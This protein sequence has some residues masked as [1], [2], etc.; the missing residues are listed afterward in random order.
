MFKTNPQKKITKELILKHERQETLLEHY[1]GIPVERGLFISPLREDTNPT[2]SFYVNSSG[3]IIFKDFNGSFS[4]N[5]ISVVMYKYKLTYPQALTKIAKDFNIIEGIDN[6]I[7]TK[8]LNLPTT[9]TAASIKVKRREFTT[10]DLGWWKQYGIDKDMLNHYKVFALDY[11]WLNDDLY[12][13]YSNS[14]AY[15]YYFQRNRWKIYFPRKSKFRFICNTNVLQGSQQLTEGDY[16][17]ITKSLKDVM[18]FRSFGI[19]AVAPQAES[20]I[21]T[22][23]Q[24]QA[25]SSR[26]KHIIVNYDYDRAGCR[27]MIR[28]RKQFGLKCMFFGDSLCNEKKKAK[29]ISDYRKL[30]GH[31]KTKELLEKCKQCVTKVKVTDMSYQL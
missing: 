13:I 16:L 3:D 19:N 26:Y 18:V 31:N 7:S 15:G 1:L 9:K 24:Y 11:V 6:T 17:V 10:K 5:F 27:S 29:D 23:S 2:C 22:N 14:S 28:M 12:Y 21:I 4:G 25:L 20:Q 8:R 30:Y